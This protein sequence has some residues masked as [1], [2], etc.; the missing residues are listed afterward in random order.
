MDLPD[1]LVAQTQADLLWTPQESAADPKIR[2]RFAADPPQVRGGVVDFL[3]L[4]KP[5]KSASPPKKIYPKNSAPE[6]F[7]NSF[8]MFYTLS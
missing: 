2:G 7:M 8:T 3:V 1:V 6:L 5:K 4:N